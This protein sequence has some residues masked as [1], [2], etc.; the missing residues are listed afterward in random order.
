MKLSELKTLCENVSAGGP[1][2]DQTMIVS[3]A[4]GLS[5]IEEIETLQSSMGLLIVTAEERGLAGNPS[6]ENASEALKAS[7]K[8]W[9]E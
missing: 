9:G 7:R 3:E 2:Y 6:T 5:L 4:Q 1:M 8:R